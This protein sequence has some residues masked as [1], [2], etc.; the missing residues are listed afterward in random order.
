[1]ETLRPGGRAPLGLTGKV[2]AVAAIGV[3]AT[4]VVGASTPAHAQSCTDPRQSSCINSDTLWPSAGP[5]RFFGV[6]SAETVA[7]HQVGFG[8]LASY[9][10]RPIVLRVASPGPGGTEQRVVDNQVTG[11]FLFAYGVTNRFQLDVALPVT[12]VQTGSG[13]SP[14]T[15]GRSLRD[16]VIRDMRFGLAY[17]IVP[18]ERISPSDAAREGGT[19]KGFAVVGRFGTSAPIGDN[20]DFAGERS[21]VFM[22]QL[23]ADYRTWRL[24]FGADV[25][26]RLRPVTEFAGARI[27]TQITTSLGAGIDVLDDEKLAVI[28]E[29]RAFWNLPEQATTRQTALGLQSQLN[30]QHIF[31][32][33]W[34]LGVRSAPFAGG[35]VAFMAGG[36]GPIGLGDAAITTPRFRF[37]LGAI[38]APTERDSDHDGIPDK[39]DA[40]PSRAGVRGGTRPGCPR[41]ENPEPVDDVPGTTTA[42]APAPAAPAP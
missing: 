29:G 12:F 23:A 31:P 39:T 9:Q 24:F 37:L 21:A 40:C 4:V 22:P 26:A 17:A 2:R 25:G 19:G 6:A 30:G 41:A 11:N 13:T 10:S 18:R 38:Y 5:T 7:A 15:A 42:P 34:T 33:E 36:G 32:A 14:L 1:M 28:L 35:D 27:G 16:T 3:C 8:M 20:G